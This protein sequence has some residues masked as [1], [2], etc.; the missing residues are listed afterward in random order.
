MP[1]MPI[2]RFV[3]VLTALLVVLGL[4]SA[5]ALASVAEVHAA[6]RA[7]LGS[8][9]APTPPLVR[10]SATHEI[11]YVSWEPPANLP[12]GE[13]VDLYEARIR[14]A[15]GEWGQE[16]SISG[17]QSST[18]FDT[19]GEE[20]ILAST[21]Y[22]VEITATVG[23]RSSLPA[24]VELSTA[25]DPIAEEGGVRAVP[26]VSGTAVDDGSASYDSAGEAADQV[27]GVA[28][29]PSSGFT[30]SLPALL[31]IGVVLLIAGTIF[32]GVRARRLR[33]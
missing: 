28:S 21:G 23:E 29:L 16:I 17:D 31:S 22:E 25:P 27:A 10:A 7:P 30:R 14:P 32:M 9:Y 15:A 19:A 11:V 33:S 4:G 13:A 1:A 24:A 3:A 2:R 20:P 18:E 8:S 5:P 12:E 6:N 26:P